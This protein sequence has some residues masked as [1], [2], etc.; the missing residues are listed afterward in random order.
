MA[1]SLDVPH[2]DRKQIDFCSYCKV[3]LA[4]AL[5]PRLAVP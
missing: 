5:A 1:S 2:I 3:L 4:D